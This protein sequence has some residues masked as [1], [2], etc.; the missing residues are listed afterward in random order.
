MKSEA[1]K[2]TLDSSV[3]SGINFAACLPDSAFKE[4]YEP[5]S[6]QSQIDYVQVA[7][8]GDGVG[9]CMGAWLGGKKPVLIMEN[10]GF[11]VTPYAL[12]RGPIPFGVPMLLLIAHRGGFHDQRW[13]SV[14]M[15]WGT[16]P[17]LDAMRISFELVTRSEDI[18]TAITGAVKSMNSIQAP[19]A[20][21]LG[22]GTLF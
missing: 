14:P 17:L 5:L 22:G 21:V 16:S 18:E 19:V 12:M 6:E 7:N 1:A 8:E 4:L 2:V 3:S 20:V 9:I 11:A 10:T 15:G 13:F